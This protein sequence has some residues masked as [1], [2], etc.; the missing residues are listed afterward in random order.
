MLVSRRFDGL[1]VQFGL[2]FFFFNAGAEPTH[3]LRVVGTRPM[4]TPYTTIV[5]AWAT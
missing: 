1:G 3:K 4:V 2:F 5:G